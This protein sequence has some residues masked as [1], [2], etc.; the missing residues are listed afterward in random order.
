MNNSAFYEEN[1][2]IAHAIP[3]IAIC[4]L[5]GSKYEFPSLTCAAERLNVTVSGISKSL[6]GEIYQTGEFHF[7]YADE[8]Y[9]ASPN[10]KPVIATNLEDGTEQVF[11][12]VRMAAKELGVH[13]TYISRALHGG[14][15]RIPN[16]A[17]R[18]AT[19]QDIR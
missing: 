14:K 16:Y 18:Y 8:T 19:E 17:F 7:K 12:S 3:V 2:S 4:V 11:Q 10:R 9:A 15:N 1:N 13:S 6:R 5:D